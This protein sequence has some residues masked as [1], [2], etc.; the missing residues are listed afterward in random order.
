MSSQNTAKP[1]SSVRA[2]V[3]GVHSGSTEEADLSSVS[4]NTQNFTPPFLPHNTTGLRAVHLSSLPLLG[5]TSAHSRNQ[6]ETITSTPLNPSAAAFRPPIRSYPLTSQPYNNQIS[7]NPM[8]TQAIN[9][10]FTYTK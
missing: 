1:S 7:S 6:V 4:G 5:S 2:S 3:V 8:N 9:L 10:Q